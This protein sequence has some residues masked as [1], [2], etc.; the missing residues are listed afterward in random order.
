MIKAFINIVYCLFIFNVSIGNASQEQTSSWSFDFKDEHI[1]SVLDQISQS[2]GIQ[3][4]TN[5]T[6]DDISLTQKFIDETAH[7]ILSN[8]FRKLNCAVIWNYSRKGLTSVDVWVF[9]RIKDINHGNGNGK[10]SQSSF[11]DFLMKKRNELENSNEKHQQ[12]V[13]QKFSQKHSAALDGTPAAAFF[14]NQ[15]FQNY[16]PPPMPPAFF[17]KEISSQKSDNNEVQS[18]IDH[19]TDDTDASKPSSNQMIHARQEESTNK[20]ADSSDSRDLQSKDLQGN[21]Q[22]SLERFVE[23]PPP[24]PPG[25]NQQ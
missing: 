2:T 7:K 9:D 23:K 24:V 4:S 18:Q 21:K 15:K 16:E 25:F 3:I 12:S 10:K 6:I 11:V 8:I 19:Q 17:H 20:T 5:V 22:K 13:I 14:N 1:S